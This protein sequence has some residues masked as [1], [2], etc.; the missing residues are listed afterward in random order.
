[1]KLSSLKITQTDL[2]AAL[3]WVVGQVVAF[4]PSLGTDKQD[5]ISAG[6]T[7][8]VAVF[9]V[10]KAIHAIADSKT[11]VAVPAPKV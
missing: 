3:T 1:M 2:I 8:I 7:I 6:S 4:V 11:P 9:L 5:L 10:A